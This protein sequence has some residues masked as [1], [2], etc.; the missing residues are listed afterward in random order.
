M[1]KSQI[2]SEKRK[3]MMTVRQLLHFENVRIRGANYAGR[4]CFKQPLD[5]IDPLMI[6]LSGILEEN[7]GFIS[8]VCKRAGVGRSTVQRWMHEGKDPKL[9]YLRAMLNA[10]GY[11][12][13][14]ERIRN[15]E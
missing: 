12:L 9:S 14:I 4:A 7:A 1:S 2:K 3:R 15:H 6:Q 10:M 13:R 11:E 5:N 8:E